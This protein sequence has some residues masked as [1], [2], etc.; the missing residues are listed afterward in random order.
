MNVKPIVSMDSEGGSV[1]FDKAFSQRSNMKKVLNHVKK[2]LDKKETW[3]Y[4]V[5]HAEGESAA[6]WFVEQ[7]TELT[8][9]E[10]LSI[11]N[12]SPVIGLSAGKGTAAIALI[13]N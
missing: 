12:I 11:L 7:M 9:K 2:F 8:G 10:P 4:L 6:E 1:L 3:N 13:A 5:L